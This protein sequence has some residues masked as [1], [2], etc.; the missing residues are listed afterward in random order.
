[1]KNQIIPAIIAEILTV[2]ELALYL[3]TSEAKVHR[4]ARI[5][6]LPAFCI[7]RS[8]R[9]KRKMIEPWIRQKTDTCGHQP[10]LEVHLPEKL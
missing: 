9:F 2:H 7:G 1:M 3:K 4:L 6:D 8:W 5:G 10:V